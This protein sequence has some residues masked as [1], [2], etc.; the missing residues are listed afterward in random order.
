MHNRRFLGQ[1]HNNPWLHFIFI[2]M[3]QMYNMQRLEFGVKFHPKDD[4]ILVLFSEF[5]CMGSGAF[6]S[7]ILV[8]DDDMYVR[9]SIRAVLEGVG[10]EVF[11]AADAYVGMAMQRADPFDVVIVD[12]VMPQK[13]GLETIHELKQDYPDLPIVAISGGGHI[14]RK[15]YVEAA[16]LFGACATLTKPFEGDELLS[17]IRNVVTHCVKTA[18]EKAS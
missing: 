3:I 18:S 11:D 14:V 2:Y 6:M 12:L 7:R 8:I 9:T 15:N 13:E 5:M 4:V 10:H 16:E 1:A 17:T